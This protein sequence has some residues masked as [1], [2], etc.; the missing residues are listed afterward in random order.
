M[1]AAKSI[2][3]YFLFSAGAFKN[4]SSNFST[5]IAT[6]SAT[7]VMLGALFIV[8]DFAFAARG[9]SIENI[10]A[11]AVIWMIAC[12]TIYWAFGSRNIARDITNQIKQ[13]TVEIFL[14]KPVHYLSFVVSQRIGRNFLTF[15][16]NTIVACALAF[17]IAGWPDV[18]LS[19][20]WFGK[21]FLLLFLGCILSCQ[22]FSLI[23]L[24]TFW[25]EDSQAVMWIFDKS[26]MVLGGAYFP[27]VLMPEILR[28]IA[29]FSPFG[30]I[31][32]F[33]QAFAPD[34]HAQFVWYVLSQL[35]WFIMLGI[36]LSFLWK[37]AV[38]NLTINGG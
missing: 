32:I 35:F 7:M 2:E 11:S 25:L 31:L 34:F 19:L 28:Q 10:T 37:R 16:L 5:I 9:G 38:K 22:I 6:L 29:V 8:Y 21:F 27:I 20:E 4:A 15:L 23:G 17:F 14:N 18:T 12:Y 24:S 1:R 30:A 13:G 26:I 3:K 36:L 33:S